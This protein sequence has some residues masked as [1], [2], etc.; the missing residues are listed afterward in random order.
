MS[1][2]HDPNQGHIRRLS[3]CHLDKW[4]G[5]ILPLKMAAGST[6]RQMAGRLRISPHII[7][8]VQQKTTHDGAW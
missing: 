4:L 5:L 1:Q 3:A 2:L 7:E 6:Y 8:G